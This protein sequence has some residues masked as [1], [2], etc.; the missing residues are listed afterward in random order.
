MHSTYLRQETTTSPFIQGAKKK[1][2]YSLKHILVL[3]NPF[4]RTSQM[5]TRG[6]SKKMLTRGDDQ[7]NG[8]QSHT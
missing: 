8:N 4:P 1:C 7:L 3:G 2:H 5:L 6:N